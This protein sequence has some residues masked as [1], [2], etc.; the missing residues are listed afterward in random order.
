MPLGRIGRSAE[1]GCRPATVFMIS[2]ADG[3]TGTREECCGRSLPGK[4]VATTYYAGF[5]QAVSERVASWWPVGRV[6]DP[7]LKVRRSQTPGWRVSATSR[8]SGVASDSL[9]V[10]AVDITLAETTGRLLSR[11]TGRYRSL[12]AFPETTAG[13]PPH[14]AL[15]GPAWRSI[16]LRPGRSLSRPTA[17]FLHRSASVHYVSSTN[18]SDR[19][20]VVRTACRA[21]L[22]PLRCGALVRASDHVGCGTRQVAKI[23]ACTYNRDRVLSRHE[24]DG[25]SPA[26]RKHSWVS[27]S[28]QMYTG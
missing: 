25:T 11:P 28:D 15:R 14:H 3:G 23:R 12:A 16:A 17:A 2:A 20:R 9:L 13:R 22:A 6:P 1:Y 7:M 10:H 24:A 26:S 18:R 4:R 21:G 27:S 5:A 19:Y 8:A